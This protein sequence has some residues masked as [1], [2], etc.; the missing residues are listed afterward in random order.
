MNKELFMKIIV[1]VREYD[2]YFRCKK[3]RTTRFR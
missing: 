3:D 2:D 1:D